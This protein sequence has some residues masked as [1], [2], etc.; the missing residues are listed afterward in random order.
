MRFVQRCGSAGGSGEGA[1]VG[2]LPVSW[3]RLGISGEKGVFCEEELS[4]S[5]SS[6]AALF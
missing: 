6:Y 3:K 5:S 4:S 2:V 1:R